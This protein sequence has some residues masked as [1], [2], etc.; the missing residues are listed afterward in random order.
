MSFDI[1]ISIGG[2]FAIDATARKPAAGSNIAP[3]ENLWLRSPDDKMHRPLLGFLAEN[4]RGSDPPSP[5]PLVPDPTS[6][7]PADGRRM[8]VL[9]DLDGAEAEVSSNGGTGS[10]DLG[11]PSSAAPD[12]KT[13]ATSVRWIPSIADLG[14]KNWNGK[15]PAK[16]RLPAGDVEA[17]GILED[18]QKSTVLWKMYGGDEKAIANG[19]VIRQRGASD[20]KLSLKGAWGTWKVVLSA[21]VGQTLPLY[22]TCDVRHFARD[23]LSAV[24]TLAHFGHLDTIADLVG[25]KVH[26]PSKASLHGAYRTARPA[27]P[28]AMQVTLV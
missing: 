5:L 6:F 13:P 19:A 16:V 17:A 9:V 26:Q 3:V 1:E 23:Y 11:D 25:A 20:V 14:I 4:F 10:M 2:L 21:E 28:Q 24:T 18:E 7:T 12:A 8:L 27:C 15:G 22:L